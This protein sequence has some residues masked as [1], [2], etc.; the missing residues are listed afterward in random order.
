MD[1]N[2][3][4]LLT[5]FDL[6]VFLQRCFRTLSPQTE[7]KWNWHIEYICWLLMQ[8][9]PAPL[10]P[11]GR[12]KRRL[13]INVPPRTL[14]SEIISVAVTCFLQGHFPHERIISASYANGLAVD[15]HRKCLQIIESPWFKELFPKLKLTKN[16]E[17]M[18]ETSEGGSRLAASVEGQITGKGATYLIGDDLLN[19]IE[20]ASEAKRNKAN[21]WFDTAFFNRQN[22]QQTSV[23][24]VVMQR[25]HETDLTGHLSE[26]NE[27]LS[28]EQKWEIVRL[29]AEF[30]YDAT[31]EFYGKKHEVKAGDLLHEGRLSEE[32]LKTFKINLGTLAYEGQYQQNPA[33]KGGSLIRLDWFGRYKKLPEDGILTQSWD[34]A[35]KAGR[36]NDASACTTWLEHDKK[37]YLVDVWAKRLEYPE[38]KKAVIER[39]RDRKPSAI[40]IEDKASG[41]ALLQ[42]LLPE[43]LPL[44]GMDPR[45]LGGDKVMRVSAVSAMIEAGNVILPEY[46]PWLHDFE[47]ECVFFPNAKHDDQV[48]SM[49]QYLNWSRLRMRSQPKVH[50]L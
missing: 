33:P 38:L 18:W 17:N 43:G 11:T 46:A 48:D 6:R 36:E 2:Q 16:R 13:I 50:L 41:Q 49:S 30:D 20:A 31:F 32:V 26:K 8:T 35:S 22:D 42:D 37:H 21:E 28:D 34:T 23:I 14:K 10:N 29:P 1:D 5:M 40:L 7:L 3:Y 24:V 44:L 4:K 9:M 19:A 12:R 45:T 15:F 47:K 39:A 27:R 25:L